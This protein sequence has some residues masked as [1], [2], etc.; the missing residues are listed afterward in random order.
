MDYAHIKKNNKVMSYWPNKKA[1]QNILRTKK[2]E[3][4]KFTKNCLRGAAKPMTIDD[5]KAIGPI[6]MKIMKENA[7]S[8]FQLVLELVSKGHG[9]PEIE[10]LCNFKPR[11]LDNLMMNFPRLHARI[12]EAR[13]IKTDEVRLSEM[14]KDNEC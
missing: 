6:D 2:L 7:G 11:Y 13:T 12:K 4:D 10:K 14:P 5:A 8:L 9:L 3:R 1:R